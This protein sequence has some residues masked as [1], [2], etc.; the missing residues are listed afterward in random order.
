[1]CCPCSHAH[2]GRVTTACVSSPRD[3][4]VSIGSYMQQDVDISEAPGPPGPPGP[5][6]L[7]FHP[8]CGMSVPF[9]RID[10]GGVMS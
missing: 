6:G 5:P 3:R 9:R 2:F 7:E 1:M 10:L 8:L 4:A